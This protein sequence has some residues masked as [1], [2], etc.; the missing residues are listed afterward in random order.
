[1]T[2]DYTARILYM[3]DDTMMAKRVIHILD[4]YGYDV[5]IARDGA[6]GIAK[7]FPG[8]FDLIA[9]DNDMPVYNGLEVLQIFASQGDFPPTIMITG[10]GD[11]SIAVE[12]MKL[13]AID[14][15]VKDIEGRFIDLLPSVFEKVIHKIRLVREKEEALRALEESRKSYETMFHASADGLILIES[16]T[17]NV[18]DANKAALAMYKYTREEFIGMSV[19][20]LEYL[21]N[22]I[23]D[24]KERP[25][26]V[27]TICEHQ[28]RT[29]EVFPVEV[30]VNQMQVDG[31]DVLLYS[32]RDLSERYAAEERLLRLSTALSTIPD[33]MVICNLRGEIIDTN[34]SAILRLGFNN[35]EEMIGRSIVDFMAPDQDA[36][37]DQVINLII[38]N[39][40]IHPLELYACDVYGEQFPIEISASLIES[41]NGNPFGFATIFRDI[42]V[43]KENERQLRELS[44]AVEQSPAAVA[45]TDPS[46]FIQYI[47]PAFT[48]MSGYQST[49]IISSLLDLFDQGRVG[50]DLADEITQSV[51]EGKTWR[52]ELRSMK[53]DG[54][55]Y[56]EEVSISPIHDNFGEIIR[57]VVI[58]EDVSE[59]LDSEKSLRESE[60]R[61]RGLVESQ[62]D[63]IIRT[64]RE[65]Y[66]TFA[67]DAFCK[68]VG[69]DLVNL[70][71][72]MF[73]PVTFDHS[74]AIEEKAMSQRSGA[75]LSRALN[76]NGTH[77]ISET[78][79][80][81]IG[82]TAA[83][84]TGA[85]NMYTT[86]G[87]RWIQ[88]HHT[89]I[90]DSNGAVM[91]IQYAGRDLTEQLRIENEIRRRDKI[92]EAVGTITTTLIQ[93]QTLDECIDGVLHRIA[94]VTNAGNVYLHQCDNQD[95][96]TRQGVVYEW[97]PYHSESIHPSKPSTSPL[98]QHPSPTGS[99]QQWKDALTAGEVVNGTAFDFE[100]DCRQY[101][102]SRGV[103]HLIL[104]PIFTG[105]T[106]WGYL[107]IE[108]TDEAAHLT[109]NDIESLK[110]ATDSIGATIQRHIYE[111]ELKHAME[112]AEKASNVKSEFLANMSHEIRTPMNG[113]IGMTALLWDTQLTE[114][115][116]RLVDTV[117]TS[118]DSLLNI[119]N[120]ILDFSKIEAGQMHLENLPFNLLECAEDALDLL[121]PKAT[122]KGL[123]LAMIYD[124]QAPLTI[125]GDVTRT[126]Q[127][128][129]NLINNAIKFTASGNILV[130]VGSEITG[131]NTAN[132]SF[133]VKDTGIGIPQDQ[134]AKIF[135]SFV[136]AEQS[137]ER[138]YGGTGLGLSICKRISEMLDGSIGVTSE[139]GRGSE[140][141]FEFPVVFKHDQHAD[142]M[143][144]PDPRLDGKRVLLVDDD[145]AVLQ[146][147]KYY[148]ESWG[149]KADLARTGVD[150]INLVRENRTYDAML[151]EKYL[152]VKEGL[153]VAAEIQFTCEGEIPF[154]LM[155]VSGRVESSSDAFFDRIHK[156]I[157]PEALYQGLRK[158]VLHLK[159]EETVVVTEQLFDGSFAARHPLRILLAE[160]NIVNQMV[161]LNFLDRMG[162]RVDI[163]SNGIEVLAA[164]ELS[165]YDVILM[166]V[167]M[168]E[169]DG[170]EATREIYARYPEGERPRIIA[171]TAYAMQGDRDECSRAGMDDYISKPV[172]SSDLALAL[173]KCPK[174]PD[175]DDDMVMYAEY[176]AIDVDVLRQ[177]KTGYGEGALTMVNQIIDMFQ[178]DIETN[179]RLVRDAIQRKDNAQIRFIAHS[180]KSSCGSVGAMHMMDLFSRIEQEAVEGSFSQLEALIDQIE[181]EYSVAQENLAE[182][183]AS[184]L[185]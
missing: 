61:Y 133:S 10:K 45:I 98:F 166:D 130:H 141:T 125:I 150:A 107:G 37:R 139:P 7:Y 50:F 103:Q 18:L 152:P 177:F 76:G 42:T 19:R 154:L 48:A 112:T 65:G 82:A 136:Q 44:Q 128:L 126:R 5:E 14:Y 140:F 178:E 70:T 155:N 35:K 110:L 116:R 101:L 3:E 8:K 74:R 12:A 72:T 52:G 81:G 28:K 46:G 43:R 60:E 34:Q 100:G 91:E 151:I 24:S 153:Q 53:K 146:S 55:M 25:E 68:A 180:M 6:E 157:K 75:P 147:L 84:K 58:R 9:V 59:R 88:W 105:S 71:G 15:I 77:I 23:L 39:E 79:S 115:Q 119:I 17:R 129:L 176:K 96:S 62:T 114:E 145:E 127:V 170:L 149:M 172:K 93:S 175:S 4:Q 13:G 33:G 90:K 173:A 38:N 102:L 162:Y 111:F 165:T 181:K 66:L 69:R 109:H 27:L 67:N 80:I 161:A 174:R 164:L 113:I 1:M 160:D 144:N 99:L 85:G 156:P 30:V 167:Q 159:D 137:I 87:W 117:R 40:I 185:T 118:G 106:L 97:N 31:K 132:I 95:D 135:D 179:I 142:W 134:Q 163:A 49:E 122:D 168:P 11:E 51:A 26:T 21:G 143:T 47:N 73:K 83:A 57:I 86:E 120:D 89:E 20:E 121:A 169:M 64:T 29:S 22:E 104:F 16:S 32:V 63:L 148:V 56:W 94:D 183:Q 124:V 184:L 123:E 158:L 41:E 138:K 108:L 92:L 54:T 2:K 171:L 131:P 36:I 182:L 78:G